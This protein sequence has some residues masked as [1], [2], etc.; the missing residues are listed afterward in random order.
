MTDDTQILQVRM[1]PHTIDQ[2]DRIKTLTNSP[3]RSDTVRRAM[4]LSEMLVN[5]VIKGGNIIIETSNGKQQRILITGL[6]S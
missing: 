1:K 4:D 5:T 2:L 3:S 6:N